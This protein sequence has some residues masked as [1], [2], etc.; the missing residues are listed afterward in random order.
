MTGT[1]RRGQPAKRV[2]RK[3][4]KQRREEAQD[5]VLSAVLEELSESGYAKFSVVKTARRAGVTR[6]ALE[7]YFPSKHDLLIAACQH[8]ID[9]ALQHARAQ[10]RKGASEPDAIRRF[11]AD[12][13]GYF[14]SGFYRGLVELAIATRGDPELATAHDDIILRGR[15]EID[16]TWRD[17]LVS[18]GYPEARARRFIDLTDNLLRGLFLTRTWLPHKPDIA[19]LIKAWEDA[20]PALLGEPRPRKNQQG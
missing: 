19:A 15:A 14:F 6:G 17:I 18:A 2:V 7:H 13:Q 5:A 16:R 8:A 3:S 9:S 11:L 10:A 1:H 20:A 4:Q 12:S